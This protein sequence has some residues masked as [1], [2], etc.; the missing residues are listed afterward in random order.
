M[1]KKSKVSK[2]EQIRQKITQKFYDS[3]KVI[4]KVSEKILTEITKK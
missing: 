4:N 3:D 2:L 1:S